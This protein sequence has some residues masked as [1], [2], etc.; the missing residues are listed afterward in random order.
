MPRKARTQ[1][2][3]RREVERSARLRPGRIRRIDTSPPR[4]TGTARNLFRLVRLVSRASPARI[5]NRTSSGQAGASEKAS[6]FERRAIV[7]VR[8]SSSRTPGGWKAHGTYVERESAKADLGEKGKDGL[9]TDSRMPDADR[10]GLARD[11]TLGSLADSWQ[12]A[13]DQR[14]FKI[15]VSP[16]DAN[17]DFERT[18]KDMIARIEQ[19]TGASVEWGG[20]VHCNTDHPHA[21]ILVRGKLLT[22]EPLRLPP[23]LIRKGLRSAVQSSLTRQLGPRTIEEI[24]Q[25]RQVELT[26]NRVTP[27][28]RKL[29]DRSYLYAKDPA[30][31]DAG[32][33]ATTAELVRLRH[34][35]V[36][37]LSKQ[38]I[39]DRWLITSDFLSQLREMKAI[40]DRARTLFRAGVA[41]SDPHAPMEYSANAKKLIGRVL[42][43]SE[44]ERTGALQT[45]F[46]TTEGK[47]EI[48]RH[49]STLRAAWSR[50]DLAPGNV[51]SIDSLRG[52]PEKL[53]AASV[54]VDKNILGDKQAL[55]SIARRMRS[56]GLIVTENS[57]GWMGEFSCA[58]KSRSLERHRERSF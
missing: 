28:D 54:G 39:N 21:H 57:K 30:Y 19:H 43:N 29:A 9:E 2:E 44:D 38:D 26:A 16:E 15:I 23:G 53:Y 42:L 55:D 1:I 5:G 40:Q 58:L 35:Q 37:G 20:V 8:Y 45:I 49:D 41:I 6:V 50:G 47:I 36:L 7:N 25:Q 27:L 52:D 24:E 46:E 10:L 51:V 56:M 3:N 32:T 33:A 48:L 31:R 17:I 22:G 12:K 14:V 4:V 34:L 11:H 18:A 13:G